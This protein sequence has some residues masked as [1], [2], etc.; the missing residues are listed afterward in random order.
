MNYDKH[1]DSRFNV[2]F[3]LVDEFDELTWVTLSFWENPWY[4]AK[5]WTQQSFTGNKVLEALSVDDTRPTFVIF[6]FRDP[7]LLECWQRSKN[8]STDP[9]WVLPLWSCYDLDLHWTWWNTFQFLLHSVTNTCLKKKPHKF[10]IT[11]NSLKFD[12]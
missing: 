5:L 1:N 4:S 7:H 8:R 6:L 10:Q 9:H 2:V 11:S 3:T 12:I